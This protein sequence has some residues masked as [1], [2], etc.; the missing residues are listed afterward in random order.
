[1][2][3]MVNKSGEVFRFNCV[4]LEPLIMAMKKVYGRP[5]TWNKE[6]LGKM[7]KEFVQCLS[8]DDLKDA[9]KNKDVYRSLYVEFL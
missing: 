1:M 6:L 5:Q 9:A 8:P 7:G 2:K 4:Q 3:E